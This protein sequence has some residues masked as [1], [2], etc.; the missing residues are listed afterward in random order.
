MIGAFEQ[1]ILSKTEE[2]LT[3]PGVDGYACGVLMAETQSPVQFGN[4]GDNLTAFWLEPALPAGQ[5]EGHLLLR[6]VE[7]ESLF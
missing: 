6:G 5:V 1:G 7:A 3:F 4:A 2:E